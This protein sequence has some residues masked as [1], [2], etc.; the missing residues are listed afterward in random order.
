M[1]RLVGQRLG[2]QR[3][4][5]QIRQELESYIRT[6]IRRKIIV[7]D[8]EGYDSATPTIHHY[9]EKYQINALKSLIRKGYEYQRGH[10]VENLAVHLGYDKVSD[11]FAQRM[12]TI[13]LLAIRRGELYR[14]GAYVGKF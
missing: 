4:S 1:L 12:K 7:R 11:A 5:K 3:L 10:A 2:V 9:D 6:A 14:N 13:F 8:G